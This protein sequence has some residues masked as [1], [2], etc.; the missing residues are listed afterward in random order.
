MGR[1]NFAGARDNQYLNELRIKDS[2]YKSYAKK[3][4]NVAKDIESILKEYLVNLDEMS[5]MMEGN[6]ALNIKTFYEIANFY[7]SNVIS[8]IYDSLKSDMRKYIEEIEDADGK[9]Y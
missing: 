9:M 8:E 4:F 2:E 1:K 3:Y 6:F 7:L 5:N